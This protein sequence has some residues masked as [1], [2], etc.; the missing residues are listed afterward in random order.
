MLACAA[1]ASPCCAAWKQQRGDLF[2]VLC[3][4]P[5]VEIHFAQMSG[6]GAIPVFHDASCSHFA[7]SGSSYRNTGGPVRT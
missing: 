7:A 5:A 1:V 6:G 3:D 4:A 2:E